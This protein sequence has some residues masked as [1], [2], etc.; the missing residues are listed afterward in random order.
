MNSMRQTW[1]D[2]Q[3]W[4]SE[5]LSSESLGF[6]CLLFSHWLVISIVSG[7]V[8]AVTAAVR[9]APQLQED[10]FHTHNPSKMLSAWL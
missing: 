7:Q 4:N 9:M 3:G 8:V 2:M 10:D 6:L 1:P 5:R